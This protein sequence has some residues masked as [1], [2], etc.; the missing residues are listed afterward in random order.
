MVTVA[1]SVARSR[2]AWPRARG[3]LNRLLLSLLTALVLAPFLFVFLWM[4][5]GSF[6]TRVQFTALPPLF[7]FEPTLANY[8]D[9]FL[10]ND[11][12][13]FTLNSL[14]VGLGAT[15][16]GLILGL[17]AAYSVA[18]YRQTGLAVAIL[19][20]RMAP[21]IAFLVPWF[22]LFTQAR[23][24][25]TFLAVILAHLIVTLPMIIWIMIGFFED[26]PRELEEAALIDGCSIL[27]V[28]LRIALPL[29][30]PGIVAASVL[31]F[32]F[33]WNNFL[34]SLVLAGVNTRTLPVAVFNFMSYDAINW[35]GLSAAASIITV[36]VLLLALLVQGHIVRGLT[37]GGVK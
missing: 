9:V 27:G 30:K 3:R 5:L 18:K 15:L 12:L 35:G 32:I 6:K 26:L 19:T 11:F 4:V 22:I 23:L 10:R 21:G 36:P 13:Q 25:D 24:I 1:G 28:F 37:I 14:I 34:F 31:A 7:V 33:S 17:P 8:R 20:A 29:T 16:L 2:V